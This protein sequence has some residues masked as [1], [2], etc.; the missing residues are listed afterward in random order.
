MR[1]CNHEEADTMIRVHVKD[2]L[3]NGG[4]SV[5]VRT[6]DTCSCYSNCAVPHVVFNLA[7]IELLGHLWDGKKFSAAFC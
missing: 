3:D 2:A 4:R 1:S 5:F 7:L 6:V